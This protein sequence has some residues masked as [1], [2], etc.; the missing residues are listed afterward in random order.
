[1]FYFGPVITWQLIQV[2][3]QTSIPKIDSTTPETT[4]RRCSDGFMNE[5]MD[6]WCYLV[7]KGRIL[8]LVIW[9]LAEV[10]L[11]SC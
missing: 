9:V 6:G 4:C 8:V 2:V 1:M 5:W 11:N 3:T 7:E 10:Y